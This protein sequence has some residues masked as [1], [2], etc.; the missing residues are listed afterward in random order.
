MEHITETAEG[1][2][3]EENVE[4]EDEDKLV[5]TVDSKMGSEETLIK[6]KIHEI[7][8]PHM[9]NEELDSE[10]PEVMQTIYTDLTKTIQ[11]LLLKEFG[12]AWSVVV[13]KRF[14]LGIGLREADHFANFKIG[15]FN[16]LVFQVNQQA[17]A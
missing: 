7:C 3:P 10:A 11:E 15:I 16:V 8:K 4:E 6:D 14:A 5:M 13:G 9:D 1:V 2:K 12:K 17:A